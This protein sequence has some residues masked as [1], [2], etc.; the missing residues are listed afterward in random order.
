M[1][2]NQ[3]RIISN[4][5]A[6]FNKQNESKGKRPFKLIDVDEFDAIKKRHIELTADAKRTE[7]FWS[8]ERNKYIDE[9]IEQIR[10]DIGDRLCVEYGDIATGNHNYSNY[11]YIYKYGTPQHLRWEYALRMEFEFVQESIYDEITK[12]RYIQCKGIGI[13]TFID[14]NYSK[15][16]NDEVEFFNCQYTK[17]KLK[18]LLS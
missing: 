10:E 18:E 12:E 16:Y 7:D 4:I 15:R 6:E 13:R 2:E 11:I 3:Q 14:R 17:Q 1:T 8:E 9:L 5:I